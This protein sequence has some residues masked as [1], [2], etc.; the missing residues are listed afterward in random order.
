MNSES[1]IALGMKFDVLSILDSYD[2]CFPSIYYQINLGH[3][4]FFCVIIIFQNKDYGYDL[5]EQFYNNK[6][7]F[8][9]LILELNVKEIIHN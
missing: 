3:P 7:V 1:T 2:P 4:F 8:S 5:K 6:N 9:H